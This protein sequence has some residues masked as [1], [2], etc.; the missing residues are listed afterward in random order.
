MINTFFT[1][2]KKSMEV[3]SKELKNGKVFDPEFLKGKKLSSKLFRKVAETLRE[4]T[5]SDVAFEVTNKMPKGY[6][7]GKNQRVDYVYRKNG[8]DKLYLELETLD[9]AQLYLFWEHK[10]LKDKYN[11]NKLWYYYGT[12]ANYYDLKQPVPRYFVW[13]LILPDRKVKNYTTWDVHVPQYKYFHSSLRKL[14]FEN[15]YRFYDH[16]IKTVAR[17]FLSENKY[18][19]ELEQR[20][21]NNHRGKKIHD[22]CELVFITCTG[23]RLILS[24]GKDLFD[25]KKERIVKLN[26]N[27]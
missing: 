15:P 10:K 9:R 17:L 18:M 5:D 26:W 6:G 24:R 4:L 25:P 23:D 2:L 22:I 16:L 1:K 11:A 14:I 20:G 8:K 27:T 12:L 13:L 21:R 7:I 19:K 3:H